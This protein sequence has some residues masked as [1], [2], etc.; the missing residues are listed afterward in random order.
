MFIFCMNYDSDLKYDLDLAECNGEARGFIWMQLLVVTELAIFSVRAPGFCL[1]SMPSPYLLISVLLTL[2]AG[3]LI[4]CLADT[5]GLHGSN[6]GYIALFNLGSFLV[7]DLLKIKFREMIGE[8]PGDIIASDDLIEPPARTDA[9]KNIDKGMR[10][11]VHNESVLD[12]VDRRHVVEVR[13]RSSLAGFFDLGTDININ[14][15]FVNKAGMRA[16]LA[17]TPARVGPSKR[18]KQV[19]SPV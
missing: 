13:S 2:V 8:A 17:V 15:G 7:V 18:S 9:Q 4:V 12:T 6:L 3:G 19:S 14:N 16:S 10:Y 1:F 11:V 5:F